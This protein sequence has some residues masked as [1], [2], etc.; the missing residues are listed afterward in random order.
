MRP[1]SEQVGQGA[2][3]R[4]GPSAEQLDG[5]HPL[6]RR[7][8]Q[9]HVF[10]V[11]GEVGDDQDPLVSVRPHEHHH[12]VVVR[13]EELDRAP[14]EG[15]VAPAQ[16]D[17]PL[18]PVQQRVGVVLLGLDVDRFVVVLG[19]DD[20]G[21]VEALGVRPREAR[22]AV[23]APLHRSADSIAVAEVE[24]VA[25]SDLVAVVEHRRPREGEEQRV[26][27]LHAAAVVAEQ[28]CQPA[29]NAQVDARLRIVA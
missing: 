21:K 26:H 17:Q 2:D 20:D 1:E 23:A 15:V 8:V 4:E 13:V 16:G 19:V 24:V 14:A 10:D 25:H 9:L 7:E 11:T 28:G 18:G 22:V 3:R 12:L 6:V 29:A 27:Q 5:D